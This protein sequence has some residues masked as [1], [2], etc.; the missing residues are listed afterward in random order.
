[1]KHLGFVIFMFDPFCVIATSTPKTDLAIVDL[2]GLV[3]FIF[4]GLTLDSF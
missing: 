2:A 3:F 1:M 4:L